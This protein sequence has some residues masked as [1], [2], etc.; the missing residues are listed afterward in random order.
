MDWKLLKESIDAENARIQRTP[1]EDVLRVFKYEILITEGATGGLMLGPWFEG[2]TASRY[3]GAYYVYNIVKLAS[4]PSYTMQEI[5]ELAGLLLPKAVG[6]A[7]LC[8]MTTFASFSEQTLECIGDISDGDAL[9]KLLNSLYLYGSN[10][11]A[12]I[13][14]YM[15]WGIGQAFRIPTREELLDMGT[16]NVES[17]I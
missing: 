13:H 14:H 11:N 1:P 5:K 4:L 6:T 15:K 8:G 3:I 17:Y 9:L 10:M 16:R 7:R 2:A 12:W